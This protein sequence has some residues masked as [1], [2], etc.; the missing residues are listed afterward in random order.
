MRE[1]YDHK[2][3]NIIIDRDVKLSM[4]DEAQVKLRAKVS[5]LL[6]IPPLL[7]LHSGQGGCAAQA[8]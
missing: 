5:R 8:L 7:L 3:D 4:T 2:P 6:C 1:V